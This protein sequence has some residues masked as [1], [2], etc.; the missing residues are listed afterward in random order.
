M[1]IVNT[2]EKETTFGSLKQGNVFKDTEGC[3][4]MV[5]SEVLDCNAVDLECGELYWF[6]D[7]EII[8]PLPNAR[9]VID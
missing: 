1:K 5:I 9:L 8:T 4:C 6:D 2:K 3:I 7:D